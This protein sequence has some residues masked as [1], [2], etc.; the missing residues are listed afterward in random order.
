MNVKW[1]MIHLYSWKWWL[2]PMKFIHWQIMIVKIKCHLSYLFFPKNNLTTYIHV[3]YVQ[4]HVAI[5]LQHSIFQTL[6]P[7][8]FSEFIL[9]SLYNP[10][11][12]HIDHNGARLSCYSVSAKQN[13]SMATDT[14][15]FL[16]S[17]KCDIRRVAGHGLLVI[18]LAHVKPWQIGVTGP[19]SVVRNRGVKWKT[20]NK[21]S[22]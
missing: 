2:L 18:G 19:V 21:T 3:Q 10:Y 15:Q 17:R 12:T 4:N 1:K 9:V 8:N 5:L 13:V 16:L 7:I 11:H 6:H 14:L 22:L 20:W